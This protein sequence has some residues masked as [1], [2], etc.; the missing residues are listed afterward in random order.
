MDYQLRSKQVK[1]QQ[2]DPEQFKKGS[3]LKTRTYRDRLRQNPTH[4]AE[5]HEKDRI[6]KKQ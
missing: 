5:V 1:S 4:F 3:K 2:T 6:R